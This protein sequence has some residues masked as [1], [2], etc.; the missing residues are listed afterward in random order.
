[1]LLHT[2]TSLHAIRFD[3]D[4]EYTSP[5]NTTDIIGLK[6]MVKL[7]TQVRNSMTTQYYFNLDEKIK[8]IP[9]FEA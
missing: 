7:L 1:M 8:G 9:D 6:T 5:Y 2:K 3:Y 4:F